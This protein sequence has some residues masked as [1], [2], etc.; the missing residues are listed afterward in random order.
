MFIRLCELLTVLR[1]MTICTATVTLKIRRPRKV[2]NLC[3]E[4]G[5]SSGAAKRSTKKPYLC[6]CSVSFNLATLPFPDT[7]HQ[8]FTQNAENQ[9]SACQMVISILQCNSSA[10]Q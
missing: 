10:G 1:Q 2:T 7:C 9:G 3:N 6:S 8:K 4:C 5:N